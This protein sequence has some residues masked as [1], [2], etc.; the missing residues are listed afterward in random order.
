MRALHFL[1]GMTAIFA[2]A[3]SAAFAQTETADAPTIET[4]T[5]TAQKRSENV[6]NVPIAITALSGAKLDLSSI[7]YTQDLALAVPSLNYNIFAAYAQPFIRGVGTTVLIPNGDPTI[8]TYVDGVYVASSQAILQNLTDIDRIEVAEGPQGTLF[9]RNAVGGA[10]SIYT[11][12]PG[13]ELQSKIMVGAGDFA[14]RQIDAY[15]SGPITGD[16]SAGIYLSGMQRD[17]YLKQVGSTVPTEAPLNQPSQESHWDARFKFVYDVTDDFRI[18]GSVDTNASTSRENGL[19]NLA[20]DPYVLDTNYGDHNRTRDYSATL[21]ETWNLSWATLVGI[22]GYRSFHVNG[23][24]D[25]DASKADIFN[26]FQAVKTKQFSR[27]S[28]SSRRT[29]TRSNGCS[30]STTT[31]KTAAWSRKGNISAWRSTSIPSIWINRTRHT[32]RRPFRWIS[33][34]TT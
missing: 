16:L 4:V 28:S 25:F 33:S 29:K 15:V 12:T 20:G 2:S 10:I 32:D 19:R 18:T 30:A 11:L 14:S 3:Q 21:N 6:Q 26:F 22:T 5:V 9:G 34:W 24:N 17:S 13:Q 8:A 27:R 7:N 23:A 1:L 31:R